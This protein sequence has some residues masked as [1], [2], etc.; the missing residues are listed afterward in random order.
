MNR[1]I[2]IVYNEP[3]ASRYDTVGEQKA[4]LGVLDAVNAVHQ[5]LLGLGSQVH[6]V[7]LSPPYELIRKQIASLEADLAFNLFEGLPEQPETEA[8]IPELLAESG[9]PYTGCPATA[10]D[11]A[12]DKSR[13][14]M[15][16][17]LAGIRTPAFQLLTPKTLS[18]F[19]LRYPC[20]VKPLREDASH[21]LSEES[22]VSDLAALARQVSRICRTYGKEAL[23]EEFIPGRELNVTVLGNSVTTVLPISE[24]EY[25]LPQGIPE[26]LTFAAKWEPESLYFKGTRVVCPARIQPGTQKLVAETAVRAFTRFGCRGYARVD[27][28]LNA[29]G[30]LNAIEVNPNPDISPG[31]GTTRQAE[32][33]GMTY[34]EFI[35]RIVELGLSEHQP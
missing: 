12:L 28:R 24:I 11:L 13:A 35:D 30:E 4:V 26:I 20:I 21:G 2:A 32:A 25:S 8:L 5:A 27:M 31:A 17:Q 16:M 22:V 15:T 9:I 6:L 18:N 33:A 23:V 34:T 14:K 19:N 1:R 3:Q 29:K 7:P 10:I